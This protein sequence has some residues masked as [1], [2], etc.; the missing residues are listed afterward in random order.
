MIKIVSLTLLIF[1]CLT[2]HAQKDEYITVKDIESDSVY[3]LKLKDVVFGFEIPKK[4][5]KVDPIYW[6]K[7]NKVGLNISEVAFVN[8]NS[9]E[10][11]MQSLD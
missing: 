11:Q 4:K 2:L 8:W 6:K 10:V 5:K 1:C 7:T 3:K 9:V